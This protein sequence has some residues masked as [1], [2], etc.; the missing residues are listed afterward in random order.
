VSDRTIQRVLNDE[1]LLPYLPEKMLDISEEAMQN[2]VKWCKKYRG[3]TIKQWKKVVFSD[4]SYLCATPFRIRWVRRYRGEEL[5]EEYCETKINPRDKVK[6]MVWA[7][8]THEG[9]A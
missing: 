4:E 3:W 5:G 7:A 2:R 1:G 6:I 9:P 8:I